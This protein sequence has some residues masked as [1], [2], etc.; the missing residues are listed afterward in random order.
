DLAWVP[1][2]AVCADPGDR[3]LAEP[4]ARVQ[5]LVGERLE[6]VVERR[7]DHAHRLQLAEEPLFVAGTGE[8][9]KLRVERV[10]LAQPRGGAREPL[11]RRQRGRAEHLAQRA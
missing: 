5:V 9:A 6:F 10:A 7:T 4:A 8:R 1:G 2:I 11:V 3:D